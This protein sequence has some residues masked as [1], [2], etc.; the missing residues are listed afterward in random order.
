MRKLRNTTEAVPI[1]K[2]AIAGTQYAESNVAAT[3]TY[4]REKG[5]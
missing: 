2:T 5:M 3:A 4:A 1:T